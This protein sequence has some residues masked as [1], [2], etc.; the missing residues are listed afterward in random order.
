MSD[1]AAMIDNIYVSFRVGGEETYGIGIDD[2]RQIIRVPKITRVPKMPEY[3]LGMTNLRG[4][5][6]PLVDL[7]LRLG[8]GKK[9]E[10]EE[11]TRVIVIDKQGIL[12]GLIVASV[13]EVKSTEVHDIDNF[14]PDILNASVD[15]KYISDF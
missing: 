6:L 12:T 9:C 7:S 5:V 10:H 1:N 8:Y 11:D 4:E 13:N 2:V 15:K 3:V 14:P